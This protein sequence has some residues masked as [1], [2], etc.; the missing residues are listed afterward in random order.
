M[1]MVDCDGDN[2]YLAKLKVN[3]LEYEAVSRVGRDSL[4]GIRADGGQVVV[5]DVGTFASTADGRLMRVG[6][7]CSLPDKKNVTMSFDPLT[8]ESQYTMPNKCGGPKGAERC[9]LAGRSLPPD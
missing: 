4:K 8:M 5:Q 3:T 1:D 2:A 9:Q 7:K 6:L